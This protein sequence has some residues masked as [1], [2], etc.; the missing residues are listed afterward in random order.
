MEKSEHKGVGSHL[1]LKRMAGSHTVRP[2]SCPWPSPPL[3]FSYEGPSIC[4]QLGLLLIKPFFKTQLQW[5]SQSMHP[6]YLHVLLSTHRCTCISE[7]MLDFPVGLFISPTA[8]LTVSQTP[9]SLELLAF[10]CA[11]FSDLLCGAFFNSSNIRIN[12]SFLQVAFVWPSLV[13]T[14]EA[15][16]MDNLL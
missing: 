16:A 3:L 13:S 4:L 7:V 12:P 2:Q 6:S 14:A 5:S 15:P 8:Y 1:S 9:P 10:L 11:G